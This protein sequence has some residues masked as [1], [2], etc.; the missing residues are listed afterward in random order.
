MK[1]N[2]FP[3]ASM[4]TPAKRAFERNFFY[5]R[6]VQILRALILRFMLMM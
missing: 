5:I 4:L 2:N 3:R 1:L 6:F